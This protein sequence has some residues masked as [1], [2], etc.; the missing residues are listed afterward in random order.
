MCRVGPCVAGHRAWGSGIGAY[1]LGDGQNLGHLAGGL[2]GLALM[3]APLIRRAWSW[4]AGEVQ[5]CFWAA[6]EQVGPQHS[7]ARQEGLPVWNLLEPV[8]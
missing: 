6:G 2:S 8:F 5:D 4:M 1:L 7:Q 3:L